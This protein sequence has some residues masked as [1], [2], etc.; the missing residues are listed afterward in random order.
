[1]NPP[2][3]PFDCRRKRLRGNEEGYVA[4]VVLVFGGLLA[5]LICTLQI[6]SQPSLGFTRLGGQQLAAQELTKAGTTAAAYLLFAAARDPIAVDGTTL[7]FRNGTVAIRV[8]DEASRIDINTADPLWLNRLYAAV[9]GRS[10]SPSQFAARVVDWRDEDDLTTNGGAERAEYGDAG[11]GPGNRP[12]HSVDE[13]RLLFGLSE[14]DFDLLASYLTVFNVSGR[15]DP[16][17]APKPILLALPEAT[18][19][20]IRKL[21]QARREGKSREQLSQLLPNGSEY[22]LPQPSGVYRVLTE[23]RLSNGFSAAAEAIVMAGVQ[24]RADYQVAGWSSVWP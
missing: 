8:T 1:M 5:A 6:S 17:T 11:S 12:F 3:D 13:L 9:H 16:A 22:L 23:A 10:M 24:D 18:E 15:I 2:A 7:S 19:A 21:M 4:L 20:D 14:G